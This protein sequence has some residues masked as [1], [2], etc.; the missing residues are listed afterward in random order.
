MFTLCSTFSWTL[1]DFRHKL[2]INTIANPLYSLLTVIEDN[3][4]Y[5]GS[6]NIIE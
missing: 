5:N 1:A 3:K 2:T 4:I 6:F